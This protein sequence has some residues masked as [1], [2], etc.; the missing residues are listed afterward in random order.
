MFP[1]CILDEDAYNVCPL[2]MFASIVT[3]TGGKNRKNGFKTKIPEFLGQS[4][5]IIKIV[6]FNFKH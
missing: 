5:L 4:C 1:G 2:L 3:M 6:A